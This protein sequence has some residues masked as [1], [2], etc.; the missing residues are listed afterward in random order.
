MVSNHQD[1][2]EED[3]VIK[4]PWKPFGEVLWL[5][6]IWEIQSFFV[7]L[8]IYFLG[9]HHKLD[10]Y[11]FNNFFINFSIAILLTYFSLCK[12]FSKLLCN[13]H[14]TQCCTVLSQEGKLC[15]ENTCFIVFMGFCSI[16][17][18]QL[19]LREN[20]TLDSNYIF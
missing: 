3:P 7:Y 5:H 2:K 9:K 15:D 13:A 17:F 6:I 14:T 1:T 19:K 16:A 10:S 20:K 4:R 18:S 11:V 8:P 12:K